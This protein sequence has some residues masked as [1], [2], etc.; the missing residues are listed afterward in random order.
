MS[1]PSLELWYRALHSPF[2][3]E[4]QC[5]DSVAVQQK[6]YRIRNELQDVDLQKVSVCQ[7]PFDPTK[8]WLVKRGE[9][10]ET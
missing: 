10:A 1:E 4:V 5:S 7:S 8:L 2:G 6:L 9:N 3:V